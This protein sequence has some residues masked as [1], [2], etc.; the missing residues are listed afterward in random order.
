MRYQPLTDFDDRSTP[1]SMIIFHCSAQSTSEMINTLKTLKLST[2][3]IIGPRGG[4]TQCVP[5][6]K[7]AWHAGK[8]FWNGTENLN[9]H[10]I[11]I[12]ICSP[13][14]GQKKY[15]PSQIESLIKLCQH[16]I[17]KYNIPLYNIIGH[18]DIAPTRKPDP[19]ISF[20]WKQLAASGI[21]IWYNIQDHFQ[22]NTFDI[23]KLLSSIGYDTRDNSTT[24]ASAY[25]FCRHFL[26]QFVFIDNDIPHL[27]ENILPSD[28]SFMNNEIFINTLKSVAYAYC[29]ASNN[30]CK[31]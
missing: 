16:L 25:A 11:G 23:A 20:P 28:F 8:S 9:S 4:I 12:E 30:P 14:L 7:R 19:G 18:S 22:I 31:I 1:I 3:Y 2:H 24:R 21:G 26:P 6:N 17:K 15:N 27:L 10:S 29:K 13:S 5:D